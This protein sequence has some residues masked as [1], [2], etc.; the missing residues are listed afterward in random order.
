MPDS[1]AS[2]VSENTPFAGIADPETCGEDLQ[3]N[4]RQV[5]A[6]ATEHCGDCADYHVVKP[7]MRLTGS[8]VWEQGARPHLLQVLQDS[9]AEVG[10]SDGS[11][12]VA[13]AG[14]ADTAVLSVC[15]HA[16]ILAGEETFRR[17][18]FMVADKCRTPLE[19]CEQYG[20]KHGLD[21]QTEIGDLTKAAGLFQADIVVIN[22]LL[23]FIPGQHHERLLRNLG[24]WLKKDGSIVLWAT[25]YA[26]KG[27]TGIA[28]KRKQQRKERLRALING[29][30]LSVEEPPEVFLS[31]LDRNVDGKRYAESDYTDAQSVID[32]VEM[33]GLDVRSVLDIPPFRQ[34]ARKVVIR[35]GR[36]AA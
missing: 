27:Q 33:A 20:E 30:Q 35:A 36:G 8:T 22:N 3:E 24:S 1:V 11:F 34:T 32:L 19:L 14:C 2:P 26:D 10:S 6:L 5:F 28:D 18:R 13:V 15:A 9:F 16:A 23:P 12:D 17:T 29:G 31:R 7:A 21:V 25:V 4:F